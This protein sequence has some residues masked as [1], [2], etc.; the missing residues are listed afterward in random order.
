[1]EYCITD[2]NRYTANRQFLEFTATFYKKLKIETNRHDTKL[3]NS[4]VF[5]RR[6]KLLIPVGFGIGIVTRISFY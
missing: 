4:S 2:N 5:A 6:E 3:Q 1:M